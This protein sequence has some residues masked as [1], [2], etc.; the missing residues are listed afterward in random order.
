MRAWRNSTGDPFLGE[1]GMEK[2]D[3]R[4]LSRKWGRGETRRETSFWGMRA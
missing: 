1:E 3:R 4:P 2:L